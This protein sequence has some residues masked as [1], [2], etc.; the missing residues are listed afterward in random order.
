MTNFCG[1]GAGNL[2]P[3]YEKYLN[4]HRN[5][6]ETW[7]ED[8]IATYKLHCHV[9]GMIMHSVCISNRIYCTLRHTTCDYTLLVTVAHMPVFPSHFL[10]V[11][12]YRLPTADVP[13]PLGFRTV[14]VT[15]PPQLSS[16]SVTVTVTVLLG[17]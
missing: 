12:C 17:V 2:I 9:Y 10:T 5:S 14:P 1:Q 13:L 16:D 7:L 8:R 11:L 4:V 6:S 15:P 3:R